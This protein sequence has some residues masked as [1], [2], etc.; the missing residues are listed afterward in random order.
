MSDLN[1]ID[2]KDLKRLQVF[3]LIRDD[4]ACT[5]AEDN[6]LMRVQVHPAVVRHD[7]KRATRYFMDLNTGEVFYHKEGDKARIIGIL[8]VEEFR[9]VYASL[10]PHKDRNTE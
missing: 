6:L 8:Q 1:V 3:T 9:D 5:F 7:I 2:H 10:I 4:E